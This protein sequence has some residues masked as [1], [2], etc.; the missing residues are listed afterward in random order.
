LRPS[1]GSYLPARRCQRVAF[2]IF[3]CFFFRMRF[4]RFLM[5]DPTRRAPYLSARA[6]LQPTTLGGC[7]R[8]AMFGR[9]AL[10]AAGCVAAVGLGPGAGTLEQ[11]APRSGAVLQTITSGA[12]VPDFASPC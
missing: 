9:R 8:Q 4:R 12:G 6:S 1:A 2:S 11:L 3:L 10:V 7:S 5:S